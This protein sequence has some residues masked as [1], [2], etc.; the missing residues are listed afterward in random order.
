MVKRF[1]IKQTVEKRLDAGPKAKL[2]TYKILEKRG[3]QPIIYVSNSKNRFL[4]YFQGL[5]IIFK[6]LHLKN[7]YVL[8]ENPIENWRFLSIANRIM[9]L[10]KNYLILLIHDI[11][12]ERY[13]DF[14]KQMEYSFINTFDSI[15]A[16]NEYMKEFLAGKINEKV[17]VYTLGIFDYLVDDE[18]KQNSYNV[19]DLNFN[20]DKWEVV[21]CGNL[22]RV[23]SSFLYSM[24]SIKPQNWELN[25]YGSG[26]EDI[27]Q[28]PL[29]KY[30]GSFN[31]N[32]PLISENSDFGLIWDGD[33]I[34][35]CDGIWGNYMRINNPHKL[36][37]YIVLNLPIIV[38]KDAAVAKFVEENGLGFSVASLLDISDKLSALTQKDYL[39]FRKNLGYFNR[40]V[41][42]GEYLA[43]SLKQIN[44]NL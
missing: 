31:P 28:I 21:F 23:K 4:R 42:S 26:I 22:S 8:I 13:P 7:S 11:E 32:K 24:G 6:V 33:S 5:V 12:S 14:P 34:Y 17:K 36:S 35:T 20:K 39:T 16:H 2:D 40:K 10:R 1:F 38:W 44:G 18:P 3:F 25:L 9:R 29:I 30:K 41:T 27:S 37:L 19:G 15:I 43:L